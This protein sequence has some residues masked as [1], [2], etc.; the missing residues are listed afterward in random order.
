MCVSEPISALSLLTELL[1]LLQAWCLLEL[2]LLF[3]TAL[4]SILYLHCLT[5]L[6]RRNKTV[7]FALPVFI[8]RDASAI[9][10]HCWNRLDKGP[11]N[12]CLLVKLI[13]LVDLCLCHYDVFWSYDPEARV[14]L[15]C[16]FS[17]KLFVFRRVERPSEV[18]E[19]AQEEKNQGESSQFLMPVNPMTSYTLYLCYLI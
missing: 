4:I 8:F 12:C 2:S 18:L 7:V 19:M 15:G 10:R 13:T 6:Q 11:L 9:R 1:Q 3:M 5:V 16:G 14:R 17:S